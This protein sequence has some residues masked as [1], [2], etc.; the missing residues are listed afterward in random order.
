MLDAVLLMLAQ[1]AAPEGR[2][3]AAVADYRDRT[4][5]GP[6]C[7]QATGGDVVV[8]GRRRADRYRVPLIE[9]DPGDPRYEGVPAERERLLARTTQCDEHSPF[10]VGCGTAG[11]SVSTNGGLRLGGE[12]PIA[13]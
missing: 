12:R 4:A 13:P 1:A 6:Q 7:R 8:C 9:H 11:V 5:A 3:A 10:Q 2:I